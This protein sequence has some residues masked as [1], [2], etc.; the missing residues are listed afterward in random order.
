MVLPSPASEP[1]QLSVF[2]PPML[3]RARRVAFRF[4]SDRIRQSPCGAEGEEARLR[5]G[6]W[7]TYSWASRG[8]PL[9]YLR[10][11]ATP[12]HSSRRNPAH[13]CLTTMTISSLRR[14]SRTF[15]PWSAQPGRQTDGT[16]RNEPDNASDPHIRPPVSHRLHLHP[17]VR[18]DARKVCGQLPGYA[19]QMET[20]PVS[21]NK[22]PAGR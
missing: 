4:S 13:L 1:S 5:G 15:C 19:L 9:N 21:P 2:T 17:M 12:V 20:S 14:V 8:R 22:A 7:C 6:L 18:P 3:P 11:V 10:P 16:D